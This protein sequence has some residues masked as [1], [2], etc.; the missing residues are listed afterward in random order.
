MCTPVPTESDMRY[1]VTKLYG[2]TYVVPPAEGWNWLWRVAS[3]G[4]A[5][6]RIY[7]KRR[8]GSSTDF[9]SG[10]C[11]CSIGTIGV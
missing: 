10:V 2:M 5:C 8:S 3:D 4:T 7:L 1:L 9:V 11:S 6:R